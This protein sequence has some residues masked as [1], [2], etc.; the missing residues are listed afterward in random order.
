MS[1]LCSTAGLPADPQNIHSQQH[2]RGPPHKE[3]QPDLNVQNWQHGPWVYL[4]RHFGICDK[5]GNKK[6][7]KI[8]TLTSE[9]LSPCLI[10]S[11]CNSDAADSVAGLHVSILNGLSELILQAQHLRDQF[12]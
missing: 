4:T 8:F 5:Q 10:F 3:K 7:D 6:K 1:Q 11:Q 12:Q 2:R 9:K